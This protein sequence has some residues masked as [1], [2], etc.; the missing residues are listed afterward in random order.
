MAPYTTTCR[1]PPQRSEARF[2]KR[3]CAL[4]PCCLFP[5]CQER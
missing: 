1:D 3:P 2:A 4:H 5:V